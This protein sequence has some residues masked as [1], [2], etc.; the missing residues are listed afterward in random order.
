MDCTLEYSDIC[1]HGIESIMLFER[2]M[3]GVYQVYVIYQV[4][5]PRT[6]RF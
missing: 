6:R 4:V 1:I 3:L 2:E 5:A